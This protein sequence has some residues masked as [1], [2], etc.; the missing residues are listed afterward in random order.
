MGV[1]HGTTL[2]TAGLVVALAAPAA[3]PRAAPRDAAGQSAGAD[4]E[5]TSSGALR[6]FSA[7]LAIRHWRVS[8]AGA[9]LRPVG[10]AVVMRVVREQ[11]SRGWVTTLSMDR[12]PDAIID[13]PDGRTA[14]SNPFLVGR[15]EFRDDDAE[16]R[17]FDRNGR[18]VRTVSPDDLRLVGAVAGASHSDRGPL[19]GSP[20]GSIFLAEAGH[21]ATRRLEL[22]RQFG[23]PAGRVG[24][25]ERYV[26]T[27][28]DGRHEALVTVDTVLPVELVSSSTAGGRMRTTL[29]YEV[30]PGYG[31]VR[32][33][34]R[35]EH[36]LPQTDAGHAVTQVELSNVVLSDEVRP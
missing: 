12:M 24:D 4:T 6:H 17:L 23:P 36:H 18:P 8:S 28:A 20:A 19:Q 35:S 22:V 31:H 5:L 27:S 30:H 11:R 7:D 32:R 29:A 21:E 13:A 9:P 1:L 3:T 26:S 14:L 33:L 16:A 15:V 10:P 2:L 25:L 34:M